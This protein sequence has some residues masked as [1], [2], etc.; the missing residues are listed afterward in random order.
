M[1]Q[2]INGCLY[3]TETATCIGDWNNGF[4]TTDF[5]YCSEELYRKKGGEYFLYGHGGA[6]SVYSEPCGDSWCGGSTIITMSESEAREWA[7]KHLTADE[8][9]AVFECEE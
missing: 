8:Y 7:E 9:M 1:K 5:N 6:M 4:G 2:I 3:D